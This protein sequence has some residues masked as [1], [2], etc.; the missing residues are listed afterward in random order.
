MNRLL[1]MIISSYVNECTHRTPSFRAPDHRSQPVR[2]LASTPNGIEITA[3]SMVFFN[4]AGL[5]DADHGGRLPAGPVRPGQL[6]S[7]HCMAGTG[8]EF[9]GFSAAANAPAA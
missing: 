2:W 6:G 3:V 7:R 9:T 5:T 8:L 1:F 4:G